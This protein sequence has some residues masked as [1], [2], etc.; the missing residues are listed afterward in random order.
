[1]KYLLIN[2]DNINNYMTTV[3]TKLY[4]DAISSKIEPNNNKYLLT[5]ITELNNK[6]KSLQI[7]KEILHV[8]LA[9]NRQIVFRNDPIKKDSDTNIMILSKKDTHLKRL[10][11]LKNNISI[12]EKKND[13]LKQ[14]LLIKTSLEHIYEESYLNRG[15]KGEK[16]W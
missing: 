12:Y 7:E 9:K 14:R 13:I 6:Y 8:Y 16:I 10:E 2:I 11:I 3:N 5:R 15:F 1:M 4:N